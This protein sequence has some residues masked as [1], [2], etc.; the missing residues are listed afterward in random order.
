MDHLSC[1]GLRV[2][3]VGAGF[4]GLTAAIECKLRGLDPVLIKTYIGPSS[5]GDLLDFL[6]NGA[7]THRIKFYLDQC[8]I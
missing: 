4:A 7:Q 8:L 5:H 6:R 1:L 2:V 3:I